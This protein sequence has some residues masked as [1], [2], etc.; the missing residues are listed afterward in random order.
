MNTRCLL[1]IAALTLS[2]ALPATAAQGNPSFE[3]A[4]QKQ[5]VEQFLSR[6]DVRAELASRGVD[7]KKVE[8]R[9]N[10]LNRQ[11]LAQLSAEIEQLTLLGDP[12]VAFLGAGLFLA[13]VVLIT[14][15]LGV[16]KILPFIG[17][18]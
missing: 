11:E 5:R 9:V 8:A 3:I 12:T 1:T 10:S 14:D 6:E 4:A 18:E 16:T 7:P 13:V 17:K 15:L 2:C